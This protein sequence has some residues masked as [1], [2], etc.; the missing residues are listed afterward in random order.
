MLQFDVKAHS[1]LVKKEQQVT[2]E[3]C[4]VGLGEFHK[5]SMWNHS[6]RGDMSEKLDRRE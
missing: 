1:T 4:S 5:N 6:F 2:F 3:V